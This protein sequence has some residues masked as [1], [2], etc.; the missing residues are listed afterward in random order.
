MAS[1]MAVLGTLNEIIVSPSENQHT[2]F[3]ETTFIEALAQDPPKV[4]TVTR[5]L[6]EKNAESPQSVSISGTLLEAVMNLES[7]AELRI[8]GIATSVEVKFGGLKNLKKLVLQGM[9]M[10]DLHPSIGNLRILQHLSLQHNNLYDLPFTFE[11]LDQLEYLDVGMETMQQPQTLKEAAFNSALGINCWRAGL[12]RK[13][14]ALLTESEMINKYDLCEN[15]CKPILKVTPEQEPEGYLATI[16]IPM[17]FGFED[18]PFR[19][20]ACSEDCKEIVDHRFEAI[21]SQR[22]YLNPAKESYAHLEPYHIWTLR[23]LSKL[24]C[25]TDMSLR[26]NPNQLAK[27]LDLNLVDDDAI[28]T[29]ITANIS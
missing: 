15:C 6:R 10:S 7:I 4:L 19:F 3:L 25:Y 13:Y 20:S 1:L 12:P 11:W 16:V 23:R 8:V 14:C 17:L 18:V 5:V 9:K 27:D 28:L 2:K 22:T 24:G 29:K 21:Q 26:V